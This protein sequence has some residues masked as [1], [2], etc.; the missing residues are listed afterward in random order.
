MIN[1]TAADRQ[2]GKSHK[3]LQIIHLL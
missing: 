3:L 1:T 2:L